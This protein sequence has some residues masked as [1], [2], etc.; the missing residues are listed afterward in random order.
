MNINFLVSLFPAW[1]LKMAI[2]KLDKLP[3]RTSSMTIFS[4]QEN[5]KKCRKVGSKKGPVSLPKNLPRNSPAIFQNPPFS[6]QDP[7]IPR[8]YLHSLFDFGASERIARTLTQFLWH[9]C[10][11]YACTRSLSEISNH[12]SAMF[13]FPLSCR[14]Q[15]G[16]YP[17]R[18]SNKYEGCTRSD[19][20][21]LT[22]LTHKDRIC[23]KR[24]K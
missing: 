3:R 2:V 10:S 21:A 20:F 5:V 13:Y 16:L 6:P 24:F 8:G 23:G 19:F 17:Q 15:R 4:I 1:H 18:D 11:Y 14:A 7:P 22:N 9:I 12:R